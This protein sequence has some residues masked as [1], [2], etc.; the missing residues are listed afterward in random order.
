[1][2]KIGADSGQNFLK[3]C[4]NLIKPYDEEN[5]TSPAHKK[6]F[7]APGT[8]PK[9]KS[10]AD[11]FGSLFKDSSTNALMIIGIVEQASESHFNLKL[12]IDLIGLKYIE[13]KASWTNHHGNHSYMSV[14][15]YI[16]NSVLPTLKP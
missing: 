6:A 14:L 16:L 7:S 8:I 11:I 9:K 15:F 10:H 5:T 12:L 2:I 13:I 3:I 4:L 1:M